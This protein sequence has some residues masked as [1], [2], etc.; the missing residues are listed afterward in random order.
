[1]SDLINMGKR[2]ETSSRLKQLAGQVYDNLSILQAIREEIAAIREEIVSNTD[3]AY[4]LPSDLESLNELIQELTTA[5]QTFA[6]S[7]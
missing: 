3:D 7:L 5:I 6:N 4:E 1:M 2:M